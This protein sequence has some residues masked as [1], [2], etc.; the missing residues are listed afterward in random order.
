MMNPKDTSVAGSKRLKPLRGFSPPMR[1]RRSIRIQKD[2][3]F[4]PRTWAE[5]HQC[6]IHLCDRD[7]SIVAIV[8]PEDYDWAKSWM[9]SYS[10]SNLRENRAKEKYYARRSTRVAGKAVSIY[11]HKE[12]LR[13]MGAVPPSPRHHIGDH[14]NGDSLD[15]RR[16]NLRWAT[17]SENA[18]NLHGSYAKQVQFGFD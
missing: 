10:L 13:R 9:W 1:V 12:I 15:C 4:D 18:R 3:P 8:S 11:L 7:S 6:F 16:E 2:N 17:P 5:A 14:K